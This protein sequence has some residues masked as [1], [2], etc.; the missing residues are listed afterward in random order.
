MLRRCCWPQ[1]VHVLRSL[2]THLPEQV[3]LLPELLALLRALGAGSLAAATTATMRL[4]WDVLIGYLLCM[5][6]AL[7]AGVSIFLVQQFV[8]TGYIAGR[9]TLEHNR[10]LLLGCGLSDW[11]P[12]ACAA[13]RA[14]DGPEEG[15]PLWPQVACSGSEGSTEKVVAS[16]QPG[17]DGA[18]QRTGRHIDRSGES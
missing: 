14:L 13:A 1:A 16:G 15:A 18:A 17:S 4:C 7:P 9:L 6:V 5:V 8:F 2:F 11:D 12:A 3:P 10:G